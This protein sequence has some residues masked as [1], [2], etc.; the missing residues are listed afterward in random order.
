MNR[1]ISKY[2]FI[3]TL[4]MFALQIFA[5]PAKNNVLAQLEEMGLHEGYNDEK[6][7]IVGI[8]NC[9][10]KVE[11]DKIEDIPFK[12]II[13]TF[14]AARNAANMEICKTIRT[15]MSGGRFLNIKESD[16]TY[17]K[18]VSQVLSLRADGK[19]LGATSIARSMEIVNGEFE[20][21]IAVMWSEKLEMKVLSAMLTNSEVD[22]N[23]LMKWAESINPVEAFGDGI[24]KDSNGQECFIG[25]G[26]V[27]IRNSSKLELNRGLSVS[28]SQAKSNISHMLFE[29]FSGEESLEKATSTLETESSETTGRSNVFK[30]MTKSKARKI[31]KG[32]QI[33]HSGVSGNTKINGNAV[34][35][36]VAAFCPVEPT[37]TSLEEIFEE[38]AD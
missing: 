36:S 1:R 9:Y 5:G 38:D 11:S 32:I 34:V 6:E 15:E 30:T 27:V 12:S 13:D 16:E 26:A 28:R 33:I 25:I 19:P 24:W 10:R 14:R 3:I 21:C 4:A 8:G 35:Y 23:E 22:K 37:V 29:S 20:F 2:S 18:S 7:V 31:L 17:R